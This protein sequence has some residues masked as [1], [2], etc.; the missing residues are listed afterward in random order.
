VS[1][2]LSNLGDQAVLA[3]LPDEDA[4]LAYAEAL[5]LAELPGVFDVVQSFRSVAAFYDPQIT[6]GEELTARMA[7]LRPVAVSQVGR[8]FQLPCCYELGAD[9]PA[10]AA[11]RGLSVDQVIA[12]HSGTEFVVRAIGFCPGFPYMG[13]LPDELAGMPR[14]PSPRV[15]V[16][17]GSVGI[18]VRWCCLYTLPRPGGWNLIGRTPL[19]LVDPP[20]D[21][22]P[23]RSGDRVRFHPIDR[24]EFER[25][26]GRRVDGKATEE[27]SKKQ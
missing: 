3:R 26:K 27:T 8:R 11:A 13:D 10:I 24:A 1:V 18:A 15:R 23:L 7:A 14:L 20:S 6:T 12:R 17:P 25:L 4:T 9:L 19:L 16:E 22:F 2:V 5:R 21:Y